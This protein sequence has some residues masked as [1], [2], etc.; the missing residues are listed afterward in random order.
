MADRP[1]WR[2]PH[3]RRRLGLLV[4]LLHALAGLG[5]QW[6]SRP[7]TRPSAQPPRLQLRWIADE[8]AAQPEAAARPPAEQAPPAANRR[9]SD[10]PPRQPEPAAAPAPRPHERIDPL[11]AP[12]TTRTNAPQAITAAPPLPPEPGASQ[13][14]LRLELPRY[15]GAPA[16]RAERS[17]TPADAA[18]RDARANSAAGR[19]G[20]V[21][22]ALDAGPL[23][24]SEEDRGPGR[25]RLRIGRDCVDTRDSR[26]A[27]IDPFSASTRPTPKLA[28]SCRE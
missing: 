23:Q 11:A 27:G 6:A 26:I 7:Q 8:S 19:P 24:V 1:A 13:P 20:A 3:R 22:R 10:S 14:P 15:G 9:R 4:L 5:L 2:L 18:L 12:A 16:G 21:E 25:K 17:G 28:E